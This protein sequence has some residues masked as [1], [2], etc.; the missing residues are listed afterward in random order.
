M[1][2]RVKN[3][4]S[5]RVQGHALH[6]TMF[7]DAVDPKTSTINFDILADIFKRHFPLLKVK[8]KNIEITVLN[9]I[10]DENGKT[11][12]HEIERLEAIR[13]SKHAKG[14]TVTKKKVRSKPIKIKRRR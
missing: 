3:T 10:L 6:H 2:E 5:A 13:V 1:K 12:D 4:L 8:A 14:R 11:I 9:R 7:R